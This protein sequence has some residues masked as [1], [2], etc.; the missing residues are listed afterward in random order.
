MKT[1]FR[2]IEWSDEIVVELDDAIYPGDFN[3]HNVRPWFISDGLTALAIVFASSVDD[4]FDGAADANKLDAYQVPEDDVDSDDNGD[5]HDADGRSIARLGNA[6][7]PFQ[8][9]DLSIEEMPMPKRS[10][11]AEFAWWRKGNL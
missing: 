5:E 6:G 9:G 11:A 3:P 10:F 7:E 8:I 2:G 4:A 1:N